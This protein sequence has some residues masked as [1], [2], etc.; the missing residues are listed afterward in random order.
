MTVHQRVGPLEIVSFR[1]GWVSTNCYVVFRSGDRE[2]LVIDPGDGA[3]PRLRQLLREHRLAPRATLVTHG[4]LD[5]IW[6]A[7][8][9]SDQHNV[10]CYIHGADRPM[11]RSPLR[12]VGPAV[13]QRLVGLLCREP[14]Q[15][16]EM[17]DG[18]RIS[19]AGIPVHVDHTPGHTPGSVT[20]RIADERHPDIVF[21]GDTLFSGTVGRTDLGGGSGNH[22][23]GSIISK[24]LVLDDRT[25]VLPGHGDP[26]TIGMERRTNPFLQP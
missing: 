16:I 18:D 4:H 13:T 25:L 7:Q 23:L 11:L 20:F 17:A 24:L 3:L 14:E 21:T 9:F 8:R 6:T 19:V 26:T 1:T 15:V 12:G 5:H 2:A 22:L 10:P